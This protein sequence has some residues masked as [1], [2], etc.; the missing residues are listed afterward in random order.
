M[1]ASHYEDITKMQSEI[2]SMKRIQNDDLIDEL[3]KAKDVG[4]VQKELEQHKLDTKA[5]ITK[6][7][8]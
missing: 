7:E 8:S 5:T 1:K 3:S 2:N 6:L 4:K